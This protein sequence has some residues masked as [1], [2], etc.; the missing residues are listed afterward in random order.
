MITL[1]SISRASWT[2]HDLSLPFLILISSLLGLCFWL[3]VSE[4]SVADQLIDLSSQIMALVNLSYHFA[5]LKIT[6]P[7]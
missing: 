5:Y 6:E 2:G 3:N 1:I 4:S 7:E